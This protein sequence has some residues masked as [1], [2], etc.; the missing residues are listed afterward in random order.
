MPSSKALRVSLDRKNTFVRGEPFQEDALDHHIKKGGVTL[1]KILCQL[2]DRVISAM[3]TKRAGSAFQEIAETWS[4]QHG[5][6]FNPADAANDFQR[7]LGECSNDQS[8]WP[9]IV[10][11]LA[12]HPN[13]AGA[14][15]RQSSINRIKSDFELDNQYISLNGVV[16]GITRNDVYHISQTLKTS[17]TRL[18][19]P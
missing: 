7:L 16:S 17:L 3:R 13:I 12:M 18:L 10:V 19:A 4:R 5:P 6:V 9:T 14:H 8:C 2:T 11:A 1:Q 15:T